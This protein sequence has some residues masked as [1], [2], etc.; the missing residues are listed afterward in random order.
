MNKQRERK[1]QLQASIIASMIASNHH[2]Q[3]SAQKDDTGV[4]YV[5]VTGV[6]PEDVV[7]PEEYAGLKIAYSVLA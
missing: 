4:W 5:K 2:V 3:A 7:L 1:A 6:L